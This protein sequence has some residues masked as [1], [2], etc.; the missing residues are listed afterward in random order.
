MATGTG[1]CEMEESSHI[2]YTVHE[3]QTKIHDKDNEEEALVTIIQKVAFN[4]MGASL[5]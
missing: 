3:N 5:Y 1:L 2:L 4:T